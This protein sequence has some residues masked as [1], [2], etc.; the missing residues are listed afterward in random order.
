M[1]GIAKAR[2]EL[3][4]SMPLHMHVKGSYIIGILLFG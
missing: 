1:S 4:R 2:Q 3:T